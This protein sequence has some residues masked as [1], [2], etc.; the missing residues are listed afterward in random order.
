MS[1]S[2]TLHLTVRLDTPE[3]SL[4]PHHV[5]VIEGMSLLTEA[6]IEVSLG[7]EDDP[8][9][10]LDHDVTLTWS[11]NGLP[12]RTHSLRVS[13]VRYLGAP[14]NHPRFRLSLHAP[15]W[16]LRLTKDVRKFRDET[17]KD[18]V[19]RVLGEAG[20]AHRWE[21]VRTPSSRPYTV[22]YRE[23]KLD[24][25]LRL[26]EHEGIFY[27]F[28]DDGTLVLRDR[29][30][31]A[32][33]VPG[34]TVF[35]LR[36]TAGAAQHGAEGITAFRKGTRVGSG[37][38]TVNDYDWK[39]PHTRLLATQAG[40]RDTAL[41]V[42]E[43]QIGYRDLAEGETLARLRVE[44]YEASKVFAAGASTV[45]G[46]GAGRA[47]EFMHED[48]ISH[49]GRYVLRRVEHTYTWHRPGL[50]FEATGDL[51]EGAARYENRFEAIP[52][53]VPFRPPLVTPRPAIAGT[54]TAMVRGPAGEEIHTD[55]WGRAKVQFHWD[56]EAKGTDEDSRW[57]RVLQETS[58][59]MQL[60]RVGWEMTMGYVGGDP[61]R[62]I[63]LARNINGAMI[64][65]Y[66]QPRNQNMMTVKTETYPG[67][68]GYNEL[69]LDD[70]AGTQQ[71]YVQAELNL[72]SEVKHD[73]RESI[74]RHEKHDVTNHLQRKV[75]KDQTLSVGAS[76]TVT[77][78]TD[79]RA[80]IGQNRAV[81]IGGNDTVTVGKGTSAQ[82]GGNDVEKVGSLRMSI[83][84]GFKPPKAEDVIP[85]PD[86]KQAAINAAKGVAKGG[87][88]GAVTAEAKALVPNPKEILSKYSKP[89]SLL[90]LVDGTIT[91]TVK[92]TFSRTV[93]GAY[94]ALAG[95][96][97]AHRGNK[98]L[99][100]LI[101]GL[102]VAT[103]AK[104]SLSQSAKNVLFRAVGGM[105]LIKAGTDVTTNA[106]KS[107]VVIGGGA[108]FTATDKIELKGERL[109]VEAREKLALKVGD[110]VIEL[111]PDG[112]KLAGKVGLKAEDEIQI[113]GKPD[114]VTR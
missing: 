74:G 40:K 103:S 20:I 50:D 55:T 106:E 42:Y 34:S 9:T 114:N 60:A 101:G 87:G 17:A 59:S 44:A 32:P 78:A 3:G 51:S 79:D 86:F 80:A 2:E 70:S 69:R 81:K 97:V 4:E 90:E 18:I 1:T 105:H 88:I 61:D 31:A 56:R 83:V 10:L 39:K 14:N 8:T 67:K 19:T 11:R 48:G 100:E 108:S 28:E 36:E 72:V 89:E 107:S 24:F 13:E 38:A 52:A 12:V 22:Q 54:H 45:L 6:V 35:S 30:G 25:V 21:I 37:R 53:D 64:P 5:R 27:V 82:V 73:Q 112:I 71:I 110:L 41:E 65:S 93:G 66:A 47:F 76:E 33:L 104:N 102:K 46:F 62:P 85:K 43:Y 16:F 7:V 77:I 109:L 92:H 113:A 26:L 94:L 91:R 96:P 49:G 23:S 84:G 29:S 75:D 68:V 99:A 111:A 57:V 95:G 58:S 63:A 15:L 98:V